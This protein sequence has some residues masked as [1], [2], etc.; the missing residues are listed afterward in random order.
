MLQ[1]QR[2][3]EY[4]VKNCDLLLE[5]IRYPAKIFVSDITKK[6]DS[7]LQKFILDQKNS[8]DISVIYNPHTEVDSQLIESGYQ[9]EPFIQYQI[10]TAWNSSYFFSQD[11]WDNNYYLVHKHYTQNE[12]DLI[13]V[14]LQKTGLQISFYS[15]Y[16]NLLWGYKNK[17]KF[18]CCGT[19]VNNPHLLPYLFATIKKQTNCTSII[20]RTNLQHSLNTIFRKK[21][22]LKDYG[23]CYYKIPSRIKTANLNISEGFFL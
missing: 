17:K 23:Y 20:F 18:H 7:A 22:H 14:N 1:S 5:G 21:S 19:V 9:A 4:P 8:L 16:H 10:P 2:T 6:N 3:I 15:H 11:Y 13:E 12:S